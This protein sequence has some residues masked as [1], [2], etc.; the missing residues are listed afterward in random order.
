MPKKRKSR[1]PAGGLRARKATKL[2]R[3]ARKTAGVRRAARKITK[4][5]KSAKRIAKARGPAPRAPRTRKPARK[6][7]GARKPAKRI[8]ETRK[9]AKKIARGAKPVR[10]VSAPAKPEKPWVAPSAPPS[11]RVLVL[12][13]GLVARPLVEYLLRQPGYHVTVASRTVSKARDL[14]G[15]RPNGEAIAFDVTA[16]AALSSLVS[17][18][19]LVVSL[20]PY[21]H[22][23][24]VAEQCLAHRKHMVTTSYVSP[25][26]RALDP[27]AKAAGI[28]IL[29]EIG[30]DPG[31]DHMS[32]MRVIDDVRSRGGTVTGFHSY[33]GGLPA[34]EA[35]TNPIGYKFSW[36]PRGVV[37]AGKNPARYRKD[38]RIVEI[39]GPD[40]FANYWEVKVDDLGVFEA[41]PNR[42]SLSYVPIYGL[43]TARTVFR[44]TLRYAGHCRLWKKMVDLGLLDETE[45][46]DLGGMTLERFTRKL[47]GCGPGDDVRVAAAARLD[48]PPDSEVILKLDWLGFF[49][50]DPVTVGKGSNLDVLVAQ[51]QTKLQYKRGE[52][53]M[54]V[55][56]HEFESELPE[57]RREETTSTLIDFGVPG[58]DSAMARTVSLPAAIASRLILDGAIRKTGVC[59]PVDKAIYD[60]VLDE[61]ES[62]GIRCVERMTI[63]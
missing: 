38:G 19:D 39:Q 34:P 47:L 11:R 28:V 26:M 16:P 2:R 50:P 59:I 41:Y 33:C 23:V 24:S 42:D 10:R 8:A 45:R 53:D 44:G 31:I 9:V 13:A 43:D 61:L 37:L 3:A 60:P 49:G 29:N 22:H 36:S 5:R 6:I 1:R 14:L 54:I 58:G 7:A 57:G 63:R 62:F 30:L 20:L 48:L 55:L 46:T 18:S 4:A 25:A 21:I 40:L 15:G 12:G 51:L 17:G 35:N 27:D 56:R 52:R 32:A